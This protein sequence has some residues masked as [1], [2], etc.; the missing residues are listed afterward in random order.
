LEFFAQIFGWLAIPFAVLRFQLQ[1][2]RLMLFANAAG[3]LL[4]GTSYFLQGL[5]AGGS[6][7][8]AAGFTSLLQATIGHKFSLPIKLA[9]AAPAIAFCFYLTFIMG[10]GMAILPAIAFFIGRISETFKSELHYRIANLFSTTIWLAYLS[11]T[12]FLPGLVFEIIMLTSNLV[13]IYRFHVK[14]KKL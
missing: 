7:A 10:S 12:W 8:I 1:Q 6:I 2:L 11:F 14:P 4:I 13:G 9:L 3:A 5:L